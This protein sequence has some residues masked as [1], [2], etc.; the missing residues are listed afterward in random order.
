VAAV[1]REIRPEDIHG[2]KYFNAL[3][4]LIERLHFVETQRDKAGN[5]EALP[6]PA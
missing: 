5:I 3:Q 6:K 1:R 2:L 4:G